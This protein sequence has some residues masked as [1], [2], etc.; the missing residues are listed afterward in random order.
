MTCPYCE[1]EGFHYRENA[2]RHATHPV[3]EI[4]C[5]PC[6]ATGELERAS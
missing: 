5:T 3:V 4:P 1:G 6:R 2:G